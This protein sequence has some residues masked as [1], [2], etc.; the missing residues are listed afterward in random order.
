LI[1]HV[2]R[3]SRG[4]AQA[5]SEDDIREGTARLAAA[6]GVDVAPEGGC[7]FACAMRLASSG[8]LRASDE[9]V[10]FNT[11]SGVSYRG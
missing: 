5:V 7:A 1:L 11:G 8:W 2:L 9:V 3:E 10:I 4:V 6:S